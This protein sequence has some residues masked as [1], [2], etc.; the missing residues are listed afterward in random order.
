MKTNIILYICTIAACLPSCSSTI[1]S[2]PFT[3]DGIRYALKT[4]DEVIVIQNDT[5][6]SQTSI[7][8]PSQVEHE[9]RIYK[10]V[11]IAPRAFEA[12]QITSISLP[13]GLEIIGENAF[14]NS[15]LVEIII[16]KS[17]KEVGKCCF[18]GNRKLKRA[19]L[20][21]A[22]KKIDFH[23]FAHCTSLSDVTI[24]EGITTIDSPFVGC[25]S[26]H[27][28]DIPA[29]MKD[30]IQPFLG[31]DNLRKVKYYG[32]QSNHRSSR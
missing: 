18:S 28:L 21:D 6:Y 19:V 32:T 23:T 9:G 25:K 14:L 12:A 11:E 30:Y 7:N 20:S 4:S 31:C 2:M 15:T 13:E 27:S 5:P 10:V 1:S 26:L 29:S 22:M 8:I 24:P 16:P 3:V 17:T